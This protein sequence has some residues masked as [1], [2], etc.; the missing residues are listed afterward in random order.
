MV[1]ALDGH[2]MARQGKAG[3]ALGIAAIGSFIGGTA[4]IVLLTFIAPLV[5][6]AALQFGPGRVHRAGPDRHLPGRH[7][8]QRHPHQER[9]GRRRRPAARHGRPGPARGHPAVHVRQRPTGRRHRL[10]HRR[11]GPVR[12]GRDPLQP[13]TPVTATAG[14]AVVRPGHPAAARSGCSPGWRSCAAPSS[15]SCSA[16]C[17]AAAPPCPRWSRTPWRS[18]AAKDPSRFGKGAIEGVAGPES[19]NNAA[20]TSS[21]IPLLTLGIPANATM[22][23]LFG[24][25]LLQGI[26]PGPQLIVDHPDVFWGVVNS[27]YLGNIFLLLLSIPLIGVF[28]RAA[29]GPRRHPRTAHRAGHDDRRLQH[30]QQRLRHVPRHRPRPARLRDEEARLRT[31]PLRARVRARQAAR[32][33][34]PPVDAPVRRRRPRIS[35]A[36]PS[37]RSSSRPRC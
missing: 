22:A 4:S 11:D 14:R 36:A 15:A 7:P 18:A 10:R 33:L 19:A 31:R 23:V 2:Q 16:C 13:R 37:R 6:D 20:A 26:P 5:A 34:V 1:T 29:A 32:I 17:P 21:F 25:L 8:R 24:A 35:S 12:R 3:S 9:R 28:V 27:M 30:P